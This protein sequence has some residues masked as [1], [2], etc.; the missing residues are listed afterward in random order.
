MKSTIN[1][2]TQR[3][4]RLNSQLQLTYTQLSIYTQEA[5]KLKEALQACT[6]SFTPDICNELRSIKAPMSSLCEVC[7]KILLILDIK[8]RS[9][10]SFKSITK[11]FLAFKN[12]M[13][14]AQAEVIQDSVI[15][16]VLPMWKSQAGVRNK[17]SR[18]PGGIIL[19]DWIGYIVE[20]NVKNEI[21]QSSQKRI[22]ELER[23][24]RHQTHALSDLIKESTK[25]EKIMSQARLGF[26]FQEID[27][28]DCSESSY[29]SKP[30]TY[31]KQEQDNR[32]IFNS[33]V[34]RGTASGGIMQKIS[35]GVLKKNDLKSLFPN[36][37]SDTLYRE[38]QV[39]KQTEIDENI[40]YEGRT[41]MIGCCRMKFFC[42]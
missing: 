10:K 32:L 21:M 13:A 36:F 30:Y 28:D 27:F 16:E 8:D 18:C 4:E 7:D 39:Y 33:T 22:P 19:L 17:L 42:F 37:N 9:W 2:E 34:H 29:V 38:S 11:H 15:N 26:D 41:E 24:I 5:V 14:S 1:H 23:M 12:L 35:K 31:L 3:L 25:I 6:N 40:I 20:M